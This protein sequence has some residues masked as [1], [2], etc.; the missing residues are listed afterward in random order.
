M[1][2]GVAGADTDSLAARGCSAQM[3]IG[4]M[5]ANA[6]WRWGPATGR[7]KGG[8]KAGWCVQAILDSFFR[9]SWSSVLIRVW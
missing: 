7:D 1:A 8:V 6:D 4:G 2:A 9:A 5:A 3:R